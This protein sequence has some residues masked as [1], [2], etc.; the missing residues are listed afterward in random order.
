MGSKKRP[1]Y[2]LVATDSRM[3]RDGRFIETVGYYN[4]VANPAV[5]KVEEELVFKWFE[6]GAVAT[7]SVASLLR[8]VGCLQKWE[9][10]KQGV[11]GT[12]LEQKVEAIRNQREK[13]ASRREERKQAQKSAKA[14]AKEA[15][16]APSEESSA[17]EPA[18]EGGSTEEAKS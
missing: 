2:R 3:P 8:Q 12:E 14:T 11:T 1:F 4:P 10:M 9:L 5:L 16:E 17:A 7:T 6:R 13:T 15:A 18:E